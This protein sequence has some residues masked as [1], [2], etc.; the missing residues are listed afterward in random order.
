MIVILHTVF[1]WF[2]AMVVLSV[3]YHCFC[4]GDEHDDSDSSDESHSIYTISSSSSNDAGYAASGGDDEVSTFQDADDLASINDD[5]PSS[6][7]HE[8]PPGEHDARGPLPGERDA[9]KPLPG[10]GNA[11]S[12]GSDRAA[13]ERLQDAANNQE[14]RRKRA[15]RCGECML[16]ERK[17][18]RRA[19]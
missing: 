15:C 1:A 2:A 13:D 11:H 19:E 6:D 4:Q 7:E 8:P 3:F 9:H 18:A 5:F 17:R 10:E 14:G 16:T 12:S